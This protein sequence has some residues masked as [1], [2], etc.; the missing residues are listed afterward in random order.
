MRLLV[1]NIYNIY[2]YTLVAV[3]V[4]NM[5]LKIF[6]HSLSYLVPSFKITNNTGLF[7][8]KTGFPIEI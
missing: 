6:F 4:G 5:Y 2:E 1:F 7:C 8:I 3:N